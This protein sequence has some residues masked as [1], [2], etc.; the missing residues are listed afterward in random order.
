MKTENDR[1]LLAKLNRMK[2]QLGVFAQPESRAAL[3]KSLDDLIASLGLLRSELGNPS[4]E[5]NAAELRTPLEQV[6][7]FLERAKSD[8]T[9]QKLLS[10]GWVTA[11]PKPKRQPVE[12]ASD[13]TNAEIRTLLESDLSKGELKAV[14]AQRAI[15]VG[16]S[17]REAIRR[18]ILK[19]LDRQE[20]YERLA[21]PLA[22]GAREPAI[23]SP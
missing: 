13:L 6:I 2:E 15:S 7:R 17:G 5:A 14:A 8:E 23:R 16:E 12:I 20:G 9:L 3:L 1:N 11:T 18:A 10:L 4:L 21:S 22:P 19:N